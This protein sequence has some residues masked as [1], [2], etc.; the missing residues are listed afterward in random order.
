MP[1]FLDTHHG[2]ELAPERIRDYLRNARAAARDGFGIRPLEL[3]CGDDGRVFFVVAAPDEASVRQQ[4][5]AQGVICRRVRRVESSQ[6]A[7]E[8]GEE[9]K[10]QVRHMIAAEHAWPAEIAS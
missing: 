4:H 7:E 5:A 8:L 1:I 9:E 6:R 2:S 3:Y 10:T